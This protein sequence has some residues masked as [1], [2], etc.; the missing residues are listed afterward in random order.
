MK[1]SEMETIASVI[2]DALK[3]N[4]KK[5]QLKRRVHKLVHEFNG[6]EFVLN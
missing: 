2:D 1:E 6:V 4:A 3:P 5:E